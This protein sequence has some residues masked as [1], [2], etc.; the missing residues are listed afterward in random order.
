MNKDQKDGKVQN[1]KGRIKQA[2][3][4]LSGNKQT[5]REGATERAVG[6]GQ[7]AVGDLKHAIAKKLDR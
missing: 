7:K 1:I 2:A 6:A 4:A 3:G 5:E